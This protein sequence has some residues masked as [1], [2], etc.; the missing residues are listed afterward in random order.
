MKSWYLS[1]FVVAIF[2][3]MIQAVACQY[4]VGENR[5][6]DSP[7]NISRLWELMPRA[8]SPGFSKRAKGRIQ[9][10]KELMSKNRHQG[11]IGEP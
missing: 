8:R 6:I 9:K 2:L 7:K 10:K 5:F 3:L 4:Q 11:Q 1:D